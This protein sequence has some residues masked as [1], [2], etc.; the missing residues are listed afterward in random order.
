MDESR[1]LTGFSLWGEHKAN[2]GNASPAQ[3]HVR[4]PP[5]VIERLHRTSSTEGH[6]RLSAE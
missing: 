3:Q 6:M 5:T 2:G 4:I 1:M